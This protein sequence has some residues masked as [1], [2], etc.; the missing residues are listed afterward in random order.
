MKKKLIWDKNTE[1]HTVIVKICD[2][3]HA[4]LTGAYHIIFE[5]WFFCIPMNG[6]KF[7]NSFRP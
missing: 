2:L 3:E 7:S 4:N 6:S 5:R 1:G